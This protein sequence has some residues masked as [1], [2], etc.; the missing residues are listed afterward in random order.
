[1]DIKGKFVRDGQTKYSKN[2]VIDYKIKND[3]MK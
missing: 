1:M 3:C 2:L